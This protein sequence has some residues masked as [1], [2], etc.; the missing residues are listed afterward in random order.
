MKILFPYMARWY[1]V[2]WTR[3]HS[4]LT[5]L[6][7]KGHE[8]IV[9]QPPRLV[10]EETNYQE[11]DPV[12]HRNIDLVDVDI[13]A[14][15]WSMK[16]P[17][18]KLAKKAIF[19]IYAYRHATRLMASEN[20]DVLL[21]YNIPQY[22]FTRMKNINIVFDYA[23]DYVNMLEIELGR[24]RNPAMSWLAGRMLRKMMK[25]ARYTLCVSHKLSSSAHGTVRVLANGVSE[26]VMVEPDTPC[27]LLALDGRRPVVGF[28]GAF[29]YFIDLDLILDAAADMPDI[30]FLL[31]GSGREWSRIH[32]QVGRRS[33]DNVRL[34]G[35]VPHSEVFEYIRK[36]DICL[37][38]FKR[39]PVSHRACPIK[40]FEYMS[41]MKPVISTRLEELEHVDSGFLYYA[42]SARELRNAIHA[43]LEDP[44]LAQQRA[45]AGFELTREKYTWERLGDEFVGLLQAPEQG[46]SH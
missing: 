44:G 24:A 40:L 45:R 2:N 29:E 10:S 12:S 14:W 15:L 22:Q 8:V 23:D 18:E 1:A 46:V 37:N 39:I 17:L 3:Y 35:G 36:M 21:L 34:V 7:D 38:I 32:D 19:S 11:I 28:L 43:I 26:G 20:P 6:A 33:L 5:V 30:D 16:M 25:S 9:L 4:L 13:P 31:V 41:Q 27:S 42:D